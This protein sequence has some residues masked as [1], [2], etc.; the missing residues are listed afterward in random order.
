MAEPFCTSTA[1]AAGPIPP[2][3]RSLLAR[4]IAGFAYA[5][6]LAGFA[7]PIRGMPRGDGRTI[8]VLPGFMASDAATSRLRRSLKATGYDVHGWGLGRN[9]GVAADTLERIAGRLGPLAATGPLTLVGWSLGGVIA[10]EYA[11]LYPDQTHKVITIGSP[12]SGCPRANH[13]WRIYEHI[14]GHSVSN[15]PIPALLSQKPPVPT[16]AIWSPRDGIVSPCSARGE[17]NESDRTIRVDCS[18]M[19]LVADPHAIRAIAG[20]IKD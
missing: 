3:S 19:A 5:R 1:T 4:E 17:A 18:H 13:G 16:I 8:V 9:L 15:P 6:A 7:P 11:K 14:A 10:R 12:F 2:P 20:A